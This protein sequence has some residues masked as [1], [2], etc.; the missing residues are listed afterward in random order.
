MPAA[1]GTVPAV[2]RRRLLL[3]LVLLVGC[4]AA[5]CSDD[6]TA[7]PSD[8]TPALASTTTDNRSATSTSEVPPSTTTT[9]LDPELDCLRAA[10]GDRPELLEA[11]DA[12]T[13]RPHDLVR[14][15]VVARNCLD[16]PQL[17]AA[18]V[19][20]LRASLTIEVS[21]FQAECLATQ[22]LELGDD[23]LTTLLAGGADDPAK[24]RLASRVLALCQVER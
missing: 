20:G 1:D 23:E 8:S 4:G 13:P 11:L 6:G 9:L 18:L 5:S 16:E 24:A 21:D 22:L 12:P 14:A 15:V 7:T 10:L 2:P 19:D 3:V 17:G